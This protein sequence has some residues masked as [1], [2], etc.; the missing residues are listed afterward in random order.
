MRKQSEMTDARLCL[1]Q[2]GQEAVFAVVSTSARAR[3]LERAAVSAAIRVAR[4]RVG[5][6]QP[7]VVNLKRDKGIPHSW[8]GQ[9]ILGG[10]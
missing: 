2:L 6:Y 7:D 1:S 10:K 9:L 4:I 5:R 8:Q 3:T